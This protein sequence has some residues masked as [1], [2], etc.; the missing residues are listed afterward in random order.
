[1]RDYNGMSHHDLIVRLNR[2]DAKIDEMKGDNEYLNKQLSEH[3][4][5]LD[6]CMKDRDAA[7]QTCDLH[8]LYNEILAVEN[9][10]LRKAAT[11][12]DNEEPSEEKQNA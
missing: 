3:H 7:M 1:M 8:L 9:S 2:R 5:M 12:L 6:N 4:D 10:R 11:G